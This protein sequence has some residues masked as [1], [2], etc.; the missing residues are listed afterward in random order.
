MTALGELI[1]GNGASGSLLV[2]NNATVRADWLRVGRGAGTGAVTVSG[3]G[4]RLE[5]AQ[6]DGRVGLDGPGHGTVTIE[7]GGVLTHGVFMHGGSGV[8]AQGDFI[9]RDPGSQLISPFLHLGDFGGTGTLLVENGG[10]VECVSGIDLS[11]GNALSHATLTARGAGTAVHTGYI[12]TR[13]G[14]DATITIEQGAAIT[15]TGDVNS[16]WPGTEQH[17]LVSGA[18]SSLT[19]ANILRA[20]D[21]DVMTFRVENGAGVQGNSQFRMELANGA[22]TD[23]DVAIDGPDSSLTLWAFNANSGHVDLAITG[24]ASVRCFDEFRMGLGYNA[25]PQSLLVRGPGSELTAGNYPDTGG[26]FF[27]GYEHDGVSGVVDQGGHITVL[28]NA[29]I[30]HRGTGSLTIDGKGSLFETPYRLHVGLDNSDGA[31]SVSNQAQAHIGGLWM[32]G[33]AGGSSSVVLDSQALLVSA[34]QVEVYEGGTLTIRNNAGLETAAGLNAGGSGAH[35][36]VVRVESGGY[37]YV[38]QRIDLGGNGSTPS[39]AAL[40]LDAGTVVCTDYIPVNE[41]GVVRGSGDIIGH[42]SVIGSVQPHGTLTV[43]S[44]N[45][46]SQ[47]NLR[48][49]ISSAG[50][51]RLASVGFVNLAGTLDLQRDPDFAPALGQAYDV[52]TASAFGTSFQAITGA[53]IGPGIAFA[54]RQLADR[55]RITADSVSTVDIAPASVSVYEGYHTQASA[56]AAFQAAGAQNVTHSAVWSSDNPSIASV[57]AHG[58]V[59]GVHSGS[60][61]LRCTFAGRTDAASITVLALPD[62]AGLEPG[63]DATFSLFWWPRFA[64]LSPVLSETRPTP[65]IPHNPN[66]SVYGSLKGVGGD[67]A[68]VAGR[69][70]ATLNVPQAGT[71]TFWHN[72]GLGLSRVFINDELVVFQRDATWFLTEFTGSFQLPAGPASLRIEYAK[73]G[74]YGGYVHELSW[75]GPGVASR[76]PIPASAIQSPGVQMEY[77]LPPPPFLPDTL[78]QFDPSLYDVYYTDLAPAL[79]FPWNEYPNF[80]ALLNGDASAI[81]DGWLVVAQPGSYTIYMP[82]IGNRARLAVNGTPVGTHGSWPN[83][84]PIPVTLSAGAN[85]LRIEGFRRAYQYDAGFDLQIEGP[86]IVRQAIPPRALFHGTPAPTCRAD[87]N[88]DGTLNS[89]DFFDFLTGFFSN[90]ADFNTDGVTNSQDFF[91]FLTAFFT[92]C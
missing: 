57:D 13:E 10:V 26:A 3:A 76:E 36:A 53:D 33:S 65:T 92:G 64:Q 19:F 46:G 70:T 86:G 88:R 91:D 89:Q 66:W 27:L 29:Y 22:A 74:D 90:N 55:V 84:D 25:R 67:Q 38:T 37:L 73:R 68:F 87:W 15:C 81:Y 5:I 50:A 30:G 28:N 47:G 45:F 2:R 24:G 1:V 35:P 34:S 39:R 80:T 7:Q 77:F 14:G 32:N 85:A 69:M 4:S 75:Q 71:F 78:D 17:W 40:E 72:D 54:V 58:V 83:G 56:M 41:G 52:V 62:V 16:S 9:V 79:H 48:I 21:P 12:D 59:S 63:L 23:V 49:G 43:N 44:A 31:F 6:S 51:D 20:S 11:R 18:G 60:T 61:T 82:A 42:I 8:G